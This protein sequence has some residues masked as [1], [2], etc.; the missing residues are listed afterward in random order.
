MAPAKARLPLSVYILALGTFCIGTSEFM[1]AGLLPQLSAGLGVS[2]SRAG[3]LITAFAVGMTLGAP[4]MTLVTLRLPRRA[5]L[6]GAALVFSAV[7]LLPLAFDGYAAVLV[8]RVVA[9]VACATY[10]AV[11]AVIAVRLAGPEHTAR[12]LAAI[13]GGLTLANVL[14]VPLGTWI[15]ERSGWQAAFVA[16][17]IATLAVTLVLRLMIPRQPHDAA[18]PM[19]VLVRREVA[20]FG[21]RR[22]W[23]A[24]ATTATF[25]AA[26]FA[27]FSYLAPLLT[28]VSGIPE[29]RVPLVLLLFGVGTFVG[30]TIGG[31]Y[32]DRD[33]LLNVFLSLGTMVLA[34][35]AL[36]TLA[37]S[38]VGVVIATFLFGA[39]SFSIAAALNGR[40]FGFAG[41]APTL[42]A[43]VNVSAFNVGNAAGPWIGGLVLDAGLGLRA[44][45]WAAIVLA[46]VSLSIASAS[47]RLERGGR[48]A[49]PDAAP[50]TCA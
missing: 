19:R 36:V 16:V 35:L 15:G 24:L 23:L 21:D 31:R 30:V 3:L 39:T 34:L 38:A 40:V 33:P 9:A 42:A 13:V 12:A 20:A 29:S 28:E 11:G 49:C 37:G 47:W 8:G 50:A 41:D 46:L 5:T 7:H 45:V 17:A 10:W 2:I 27:C 4:L 43:S 6:L 25:Q 1:L 32:A 44:P 48:P 22:L 26:V 18:T 14:G